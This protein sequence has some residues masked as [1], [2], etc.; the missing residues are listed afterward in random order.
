MTEKGPVLVLVELDRDRNCLPV[1]L[2]CLTLGRSLSAVLGGGLGALVMGNAAAAAAEELSRRDL[3]AVYRVE[4]PLLKAWHPELC[5]AAFVQACER[6]RPRAILMGDTLN[7][8]DLAPR[9]AVTLNTG[10][11]TDCVGLEFAQGEV[12]FLKPVYSSNVMAAYTFAAEPYLATMRSRSGSP[13][14]KKEGSAAD[15][16][17]VEV[18]LDPATVKVEV[19]ERFVEEDPENRLTGADIV[20]SGGRG[21]GGPEGFRQLAALAG[22]LGAAVGA[23]R[24]PCDL[25]WAPARAQVGQTGEKVAPGVYIAVGISGA[26]Q[27]LA[28]MHGSRKIVAINRDPGANIFRVA[29]YGVVGNYEEILPAFQEALSE[30]L[31]PGA[32]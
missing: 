4:H 7:A 32:A 13:G 24:P 11:V 2:E 5:L 26:T 17:P 6:I 25:G 29:D 9:I 15:I 23:S 20:V 14:R 12:E 1:S 8:V 30:I 16:I 10:L 21:M 22:V 19:V 31:D 18:E 27:H 28:G 3:D